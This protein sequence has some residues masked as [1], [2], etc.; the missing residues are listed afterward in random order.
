MHEVLQ[1]LEK[2]ASRKR[3]IVL[4]DLRELLTA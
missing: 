1:E 4:H 2:N 3:H